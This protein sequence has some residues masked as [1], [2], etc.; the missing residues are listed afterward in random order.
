MGIMRTQEEEYDGNAEQEF[1]GRCVLCAVVDL[2]PHI[3]V[4]VSAAV[5]VEWHATDVVEHDIRAEHVGYVG[6]RPG[7]LLGD[8]RYHVPEDLQRNDQNNVDSPR[9]CDN[10]GALVYMAYL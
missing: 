6:Q 10:G 1:L 2:L 3:Q 5:E 9:S 4:V 7:S 8:T